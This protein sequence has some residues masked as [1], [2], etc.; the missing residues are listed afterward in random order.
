[1]R[2]VASYSTAATVSPEETTKYFELIIS[3]INS[4]LE[5]K[6]HIEKTPNGGIIRYPNEKK[7][8]YLIEKI[9]SSIGLFIEF[10][11]TEQTDTGLFQTV[12]RAGQKDSLLSVYAELRVGSVENTLAPL[13]FDARCPSVIR[14]II[15]LNIDWHVGQVPVSTQPVIFIGRA[16]ANAL[17]KI[18]W[19]PQRTLPIVVVSEYEGETLT[20]QIA[21]KLAADLS[22]LAIVAR[23]DSEASWEITEIKG[24]EWSCFNGAVRLYW[25]ITNLPTDHRAHPLWTRFSLLKGI[26]E[27]RDASY[28]LRKLL[29]KKILG[30]SAFSM[31]E[32]Q[33]IQE[34]RLEYRKE[35]YQE[36][37]GSAQSESDWKELADLYANDNQELAQKLAE[38]KTEKEQLQAHVASLL[39]ALEWKSNTEDEI[40]AAT[41]IPPS[42]I[43][44]AVERAVSELAEHLTF[45]DDV[46]RGIETLAPDAGPPEKILLCLETLANLAKEKRKGAIGTTAI[47][48]LKERGINC[49][50][51]SETIRNS[52]NASQIRTWHDGGKRR[53][54]ENHLKPSDGTRPERCVRIYF[55]DDIQ[56]GRI[57]I[58]WV[59]R[60]PD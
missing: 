50:C 2:K 25:P 8:E 46:W 21:N 18:L 53:I 6:G 14:E 15:N 38:A 29:R 24:R 39:E 5:G 48:W 13:S 41:D 3:T 17:M 11:L 34:I 27:P 44:E 20:P 23:T 40:E 33:L 36:R 37:K 47:Q 51:E 19:H 16:G 9:Q 22:G 45:G 57:V 56:S 28:R 32:H 60:H 12:I 49:S 10:D 1:M 31:R 58:G 35:L 26:Y 55:D 4:W 7:A 42:T 52:K 54:F 43:K 59:G 30:S